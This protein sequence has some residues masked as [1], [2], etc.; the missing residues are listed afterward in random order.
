MIIKELREMA[1]IIL[2]QLL[3]IDGVW[4]IEIGFDIKE[5]ALCNW[6]TEQN[7]ESLSGAVYSIFATILFIPHV[8][9]LSSFAYG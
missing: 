5:V 4:M 6:T 1:L 9:G 2:K 8:F 3:N 7:S